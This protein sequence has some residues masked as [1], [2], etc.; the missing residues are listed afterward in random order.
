MDNIDSGQ[1]EKSIHSTEFVNAPLP[2]KSDAEILKEEELQRFREFIEKHS[3][4][5]HAKIVTEGT[6]WWEWISS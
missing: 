3:H 6:E 4:Q 1:K 2:K 5:G